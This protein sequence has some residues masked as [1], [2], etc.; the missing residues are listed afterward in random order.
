MS[1][2]RTRVHAAQ[3]ALAIVLIGAVALL[4]PE[5]S[6][7]PSPAAAETL[8]RVHVI[9]ADTIEAQGQRIRIVNIDTPEVG[10]GARCAA[11]RRLGVRA[12]QRTHALI[13]AAARVETHPTGRT[14]AY[15]RTI[16][17]VSIDGRDLGETLIAEASPGLGAADAS[18]G[19][20]HAT[21]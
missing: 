8:R 13:Q 20:T 2:Q 16:A 11:E 14:D 15:G 12:T 9:D 17:Y 21:G 7:A 4:S 18:P 19:A 1:P 5:P 6:L 10:A 3:A